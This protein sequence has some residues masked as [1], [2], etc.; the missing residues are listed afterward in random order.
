M[1][2]MDVGRSLSQI[3][4]EIDLAVVYQAIPR[5]PP[6]PAARPSCRRKTRRRCATSSCRS[7]RPSGPPKRRPRRDNKKQA[8]SSPAAKK[9]DK[10]VKWTESGLGYEV[11]KAGNGPKLRHRHGEVHYTGTLIDGAKFDNS[12][13]R[14]ASQ[15]PA[16]R[17]DPRLTEGLQLMPVGSVQVL[18]SVEPG[19]WRARP[20]PIGPNAT[21][22]FDVEL[23]K[24][25][26]PASDKPADGANRP[27]ERSKRPRPRA[28]RGPRGTAIPS[29]CLCFAA[30]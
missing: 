6:S 23:L 12:V 10:N 28:T 4:D 9:A 29:P 30:R 20:G 17:C 14:P 24:I 27:A 2:G 25:M 11:V 15:L 21:L 5:R 1:V 19:L 16:Q 18:H 7:S 26:P 22:I 3:K 13:D 8:T